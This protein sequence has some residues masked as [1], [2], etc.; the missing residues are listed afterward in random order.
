MS[1]KSTAIWIVSA[2]VVVGAGIGVAAHAASHPNSGHSAT[3][4]AAG[5]TAVGAIPRSSATAQHEGDATAAPIP[6][7]SPAPQASS[8]AG[9]AATAPPAPSKTAA[10]T[11]KAVIPSLSYYSFTGSTLTLGGGVSGLVDSSGTCAV[12]VTSGTSSVS[13]SFAAQAGPS[14]TDCGA[15]AITS[16]K[17]HS[18]TWHVSIVYSSPRARGSSTDSEVTL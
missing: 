1:R 18:G 10:A 13:Q 12:T 2:V 6:P 16:T 17:F 4:S 15:M 9:T 5:P 8:P 11:V 14:S 7:T 3:S